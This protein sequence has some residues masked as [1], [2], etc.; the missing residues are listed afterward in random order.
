MHPTSSPSIRSFQKSLFYSECIDDKHPL[1]SHSF[2]SFFKSLIYSG[3]T[4]NE[5]PLGSHSFK[6]FPKDPWSKVG[7]SMT[8][9]PQ[10]HI[11][12]E[13]FQKSLIYSGCTNDMRPWAHALS[14]I[15]ESLIHYSRLSSKS[16]YPYPTIYSQH[17]NSHTH[18]S[19]IKIYMSISPKVT[20]HK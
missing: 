3:C 5:R 1:G 2:R 18:I 11:H 7:A 15:F 8:I 14:R 16:P 10:A 9:V 4:N 13:V 20:W 19:K 12:S 17:L 6:S